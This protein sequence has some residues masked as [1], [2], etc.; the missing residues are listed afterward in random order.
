MRM[1][2]K[3]VSQGPSSKIGNILG[4]SDF[5]FGTLVGEVNTIWVLGP[6]G[7]GSVETPSTLLKQGECDSALP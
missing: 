1:P 5:L 3:I 4:L 6:S 2:Y 7:E